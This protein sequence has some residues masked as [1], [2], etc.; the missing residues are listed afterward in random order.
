MINRNRLVH[1][2]LRGPERDVVTSTRRQSQ[3]WRLGSRLLQQ[4]SAL[5]ARHHRQ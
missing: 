1:L 5:L 2:V 3:P 4:R